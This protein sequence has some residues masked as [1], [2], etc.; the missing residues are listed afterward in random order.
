MSYLKKTSAERSKAHYERYKEQYQQ[1]AREAHVVGTAYLQS[2]KAR[3]GCLY[4]GE[5]L[6]I[7]LAFHHRDPNTKS[8][9][10]SAGSRLTRPIIDK[11]VAKCDV[12]C[13]NC[14]SIIHEIERLRGAA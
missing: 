13:A 5:N 3:E 8:F 6:P 9:G 2:I 11:E 1:R 7:C 14:H 10:L 12:V 4:C